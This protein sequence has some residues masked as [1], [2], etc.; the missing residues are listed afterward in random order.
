M[1]DRLVVRGAREHN[2]KDVS[3]DLPRDALIVFTGLSGS[4]KS[5]LAFDTIFAEGQRRYV[6]SLSAYARQFLGQMD[7]PDVDFIEGL[8]PA[9]SID[10]KSTSRNPRSTVGTITE[11]YDY[12]RLL[13][14]RAGTPHCPK[15]GRV[16]ARQ[17][18][19][20]IVDR[21]LELEEGTRFQV[22]APV[23]RAR[24]G[25]YV[26]LFADLQTKG[27]SRARVDGVVHSL[28]EPPTLKKQEKHTIEVVVDRLTVKESAK[29]R[30]TD[31]VETALGLGS[32]LVVLDFVDKPEDDP[33][34]ERTFSEHL[35][36]LYDDLS[37][38]ELEPRSFSFNSP[39]G[40]CP[41]C[42][43]LGTQREVDPELVITDQEASFEQGVIAPWS[44]GHNIEYFGRLVQALGDA[45]GFTT[46][47]PWKKLTASQQ[48]AVLHG[49]PTEVHVRYRNRY[50]RE[51]SYYTAY[52]GVI[53][54]L[55]RRHSEA[56][57]ETS[58]ERF[59]GYMREVPCGV[60]KGARL[61]PEVLA[62]TLG[63]RS[64]ADVAAMSIAECAAFLR[65]LEL[66]ARQKVIAERV[67]KEV[68]ARLGFLLDVGLDYLSLDRAAG[69]LAGGEAQRIRLATQIGSGLVGVLYVLDEPSIGL[70]QRDNR[71]LIDTLLRLKSL[72][73]TL[74]VVEHDE[75]T[76]QTAD[77]VVD[78]GPGAGEHGGQVV[79]S[80]SVEEL[81]ASE[82][83]ITGAYLSGRR[84]IP[85]PP[86]RRPR[87][88]GREL[89]V[90]GAR[91]H[92][93]RDVTV[94]F[95]LGQL[96]AVT[97][98]SGSGKSTL[99]NDIL[100][101]VLVKHLNGNREVPG[102]H[103]RVTGL[104]HLDK[105]VRVDQSP[106]GRTPRSNPATYTG[107]FD[108]MRKLFA[109]TTE[110]K[111]RG[112]LPGRF[113]FNV[114]GGRCEACSGD[115]TIKI[116]MNF[117]PDVYVP[118]EVCSGARYNRETLEV[119]FKG[120]SISEILDMPIEEAAEFFE[121]VP[122]IRRHLQTL[123]EV[124]LGYVRLGQPAPTLSGGEAQR[125]KLAA[126]LQKRQTG[127]TIYVLD[128]PTTGLHFEDISKL[129]GVLHRLVDAGNSVVV[130]E[131]NLDVIKT[132]DWIVDM[133]PEG[134]SGGGTVVAQGTPEQ[135]A[136]VDASHT[137]RFLAEILGG[138]GPAGHRSPAGEPPAPGDVKGRPT[139]HTV[140]SPAGPVTSGPRARST[141]GASTPAPSRSAARA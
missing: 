46:K 76:I 106:I 107:V 113:S 82:H 58:R 80:G 32:G 22:L 21:V 84:E 4:G 123:V 75:D 68:N 8:S 28:A 96:V 88:K 31:S 27:Y 140:R 100:A 112:Y 35:A 127:R 121:S 116:E 122:A 72:G 81:L 126:E 87:T 114:K 101:A 25:E 111:V 43:G 5:S 103:T 133:G 65:E 11:V 120:K 129:L 110:A 91:E 2:L 53:P 119:H 139:V 86:V 33:E 13:Y 138:R 52:E 130:I 36:C 49:H 125:V 66:D 83:S 69:T 18:P 93:L 118:C 55:E 105:V 90:V 134:G 40:A 56:E 15:C 48:K 98:V 44:S 128:E 89:T 78:I 109:E 124:G 38:E 51:R 26:D 74:I 30:L 39:F 9:V 19:S 71:R 137:G 95:P 34:R 17:Q 61:K 47:T 79:V 70:H 108:H 104:D 59:E 50:G 94:A 102:R 16:I 99:V 7:K 37:F 117:L 1:A 10:Q 29:R 62:V 42:H 12:L 92:N 14:A 67:V 57:S 132:A 136:T 131:H 23:V 3:L 141:A 20:Q 135:V 24:K 54:F 6:E 97:G 41:E 64:I 115:G 77:W 73:N 85:V 60:C 45:L 63:D